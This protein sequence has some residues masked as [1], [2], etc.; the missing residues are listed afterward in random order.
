MKQEIDYTDLVDKDNI[1][2][3]LSQEIPKY[4][5]LGNNSSLNNNDFEY[6]PT[7]RYFFSNQN[8]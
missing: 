8:P 7:P 1:Y 5:F 3:N 2:D 4:I 6:L